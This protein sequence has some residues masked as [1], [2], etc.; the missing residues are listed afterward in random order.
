LAF[1]SAALRPENFPDYGNYKIIFEESSKIFDGQS[2]WNI[3]SEPGYKLINFFISSLGLKYDSLLVFMSFLSLILLIVISRISEIKF[4]YLWFAYFS[5]YYVTRDLGVIR[6]S[7]ASHLIVISVLQHSLANKIAINLI[8]CATFQYYSFVTLI[9][10]FFNKLK[11]NFKIIYLL[12]ILS[13]LS[14][15]LIKMDNINFLVPSVNKGYIGDI[16]GSIAYSKVVFPF[17]RNLVLGILIYY[18]MF[19]ILNKK[20]YVIIWMVIFSILSG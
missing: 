19:I 20:N 16:Q 5:L 8:S 7:I 10:I 18:F 13:V 12:L 15:F 1:V 4:V 9:S 17:I 2:F 3:H 6:V 14:A 11:P